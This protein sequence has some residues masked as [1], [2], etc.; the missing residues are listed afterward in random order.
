VN[1]FNL[2]STH[3]KYCATVQHSFVCYATVKFHALTK[4]QISLLLQTK[5]TKN[6]YHQM[7]FLGPNSLSTLETIVADFG[8]YSLQCG[9]GLMLQECVG[10]RGSAPDPA[11]EAY[12]TPRHLSGISRGCFVTGKGKERGPAKEWVGVKGTNREEGKGR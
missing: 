7:R 9:Q 11:R 12:S 6:C 2:S 3:L 8:D 1:N 10:G 5:V 4:L